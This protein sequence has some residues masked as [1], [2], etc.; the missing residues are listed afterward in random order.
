MAIA[1]E[2]RL[3]VSEERYG[4]AIAEEMKKL[5]Y[6]G[7]IEEI[8]GKIDEN[9]LKLQEKL[10]LIDAKSKE[11]AQNTEA[12]FN[13][14][15]LALKDEV[16]CLNDN[17]A[18]NISKEAQNT[19]KIVQEKNDSLLEAKVKNMQEKSNKVFTKQLNNIK[20]QNQEIIN[21]QLE[22]VNGQVVSV[23]NKEVEK[24]KKD[25]RNILNER[26]ARLQIQNEEEINNQLKKMQEGNSTLISSIVSKM[27]NEY[28]K[29]LQK[30]LKQMQDEFDEKL[31]NAI[32]NMQNQTQKQIKTEYEKPKTATVYTYEP[33]LEKY[34]N[35]IYKSVGSTKVKRAAKGIDTEKYLNND[36][37]NFFED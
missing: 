5:N 25:T 28:D 35:N 14:K 9:A 13:E 3:E 29:K 1:V 20:L 27:Q 11:Y 15:F 19:L 7:T 8:N 30:K 10:G 34:D 32:L 2:E 16:N 31:K 24:L 17:I 36:I 4:L 33:V 12:G 22:G 26:L 37:I 23:L 21:E 18:N 6:Q